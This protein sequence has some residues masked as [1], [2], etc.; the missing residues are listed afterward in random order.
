MSRVAREESPTGYYHILVRG[1]NRSYIFNNQRY[2]AAFMEMIEEQEKDTG[3]ELAAWCIMDNHVHLV[4][5]AE[6]D[7][8]SL[9]MKRINIKFAMMYNQDQNMVGHV[10]Q[11]RF[12]S[13]VIDSDEYLLQVVR[14]VHNNPVSAKI[15]KNPGDYKWSSYREYLIRSQVEKRDQYRIVMEL[16]NDKLESF[17]E[18]HTIEDSKEYLE[19]K[20]DMERIREEKAQAIISECFSKHGIDEMVQIRGD[21]WIKN[22]LIGN[23]IRKS[24]LSYRSISRLLEL[25]YSSVREVGKDILE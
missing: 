23:L 22:E 16:F 3:I 12:K 15:V 21:G 24:G 4:L 18:F 1:N 19:I 7:Q 6:L 2:K 11:D 25:P 10:F 5:K 13:H 17:E 9:A 8:L 20:E 14:Y